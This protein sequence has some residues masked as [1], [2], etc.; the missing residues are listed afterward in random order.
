MGNLNYIGGIAKILEI[1][2][3]IRLSSKDLSLSFVQF[4]V[5][6]LSRQ[7]AYYYPTITLIVW[8]GLASQILDNYKVNDYVLMEGHLLLQPLNFEHYFEK[9]IQINVTKIFRFSFKNKE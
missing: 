8:G 6:F 5:Q 2:S 3:L 7:E 1:P 9:Q 4:R